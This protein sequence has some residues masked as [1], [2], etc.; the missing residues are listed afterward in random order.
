MLAKYR[1]EEQTK[2]YVVLVSR[3]ASRANFSMGVCSRGNLPWHTLAQLVDLIPFSC[4]HAICL[5]KA[6]GDAIGGTRIEGMCIT[7]ISLES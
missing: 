4:S 1:H 3:A 7:K 5:I 2:S 6:C